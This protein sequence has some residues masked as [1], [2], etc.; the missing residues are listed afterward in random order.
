MLDHNLGVPTNIITGFLGVGKTTAILGLLEHKPKDERWAVLVNEFGEVGIDG[1]LRVE[2]EQLL[3]RARPPRLLIEPSGL[4]HPQEVLQ[5]LRDEKFSKLLAI[6]K[7]ITIVDARHLLNMRCIDDEIFQEQIAIADIIVAN[8]QDLL[9]AN[10]KTRL[11]A[12]LR[13]NHLDHVKLVY[14]EQAVIDLALLDGPT[15]V[16]PKSVTQV[17]ESNSPHSHLS[18]DA[19]IPKN[20]FIKVVNQNA[21]YIS[22]GWRFSSRYGF[23]RQKLAVFLSAINAQRVK[24]TFI[25]DKGDFG[26]NLARDDLSETA[27]ERF[28]ESRIEIVAWLP[29]S[30]WESQLFDCIARR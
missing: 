22:I 30:K 19:A 7:L 3:K 2:L 17:I 6:Q 28:L 4:G 1:T 11:N 29:S 25:T 26:Y 21:G 10:D 9:V 18:G 20:G 14:T 16:V 27:Y 5:A 23:D 8:K 15:K 13:I 12:Y 24:A